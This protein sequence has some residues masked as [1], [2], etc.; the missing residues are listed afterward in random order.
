MKPYVIIDSDIPFIN[1]VLEPYFRVR[2]LKGDKITRGD[3]LSAD[4]LIIRTRTKC[5]E[6]L[7]KGSGVKA[8]FTATIGTDHIDSEYCERN[9]I[10]VFNAAGCNACGV[11]QYVLTSLYALCQSNE[12]PVTEMKMGIVGAG[13]VGERLA[14][15][16]YSIG[17][18]VMRCDPPKRELY[19]NL[20]DISYYDL[21]E[22]LDKCSIIS[23]HVPLN[24][25]TK[26]MCSDQFFEKMK[27][28]AIFINSSRGEVVNE[29]SLLKYK[30]KLGGVIID[31]WSSEP[32]I[33]KDL[34]Q[35]SDISTPHIA[36]YSLEGKINA[37]VYT[38]QNISG[39]FDINELKEFSIFPDKAP[40]LSHNY[41][42]SRGENFNIY[43]LLTQRFDIL[44]E[45]HLLKSNPDRFEEYR[46]NYNYRR[47]ITSD[48]IKIIDNIKENR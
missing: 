21:D 40:E 13:N 46:V 10:A 5:N 29:P 38:I 14:I 31:V 1:G 35:T 24:S 45:S 22:L 27:K 32:A 11:V 16:A 19:K 9:G 4:S 48:D 18:E 2:Y 30:E 39:F 3:L 33:N 34:L 43:S 12:T 44:S 42:K 28:G 7:L 41:D 6:A 17:F 26:G 47:E 25:E 15:T 23:M 20:S 8:I 36:G 37:T